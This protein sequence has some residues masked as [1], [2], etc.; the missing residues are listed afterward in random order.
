M[1]GKAGQHGP[2]TDLVTPAGSLILEDQLKRILDLDSYRKMKQSRL[3]PKSA[4]SPFGAF[5]P[6]KKPAASPRLSAR[7]SASPRLPMS[8]RSFDEIPD[9]RQFLKKGQG[10]GG[11]TS[12]TFQGKM[13]A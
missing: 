11:L 9:R 10:L 5:P 7:G 2:P 3:L 4:P 12:S 13:D 8:P 1:L 6:P